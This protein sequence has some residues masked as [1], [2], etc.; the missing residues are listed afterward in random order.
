MCNFQCSADS[1][2][3]GCVSLATKVDIS[4]AEELHALYFWHAL[5]FCICLACSVFVSGIAKVIEDN[6]FVCLLV[7]FYNKDKK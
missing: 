1:V 2:F 7:S 5:Y 4:L 6:I 3:E